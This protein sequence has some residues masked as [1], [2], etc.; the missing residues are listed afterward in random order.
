MHETPQLVVYKTSELQALIQLVSIM[1][2]MG[3][4]FPLGDPPMPFNSFYDVFDLYG[5]R[6]LCDVPFIAYYSM[7]A[8]WHP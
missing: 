2:P 3:P 5:F 8:K 6:A 7:Q 4:L 1:G